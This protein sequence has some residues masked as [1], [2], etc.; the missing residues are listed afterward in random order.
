[1]LGVSGGGGSETKTMSEWFIRV[2]ANNQKIENNDHISCATGFSH[3]ENSPYPTGVYQDTRYRQA[4]NDVTREDGWLTSLDTGD[5]GW[6]VVDDNEAR[7]HL[8]LFTAERN[9]YT[10]EI[11]DSALELVQSS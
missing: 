8:Q 1:L 3:L 11:V 6:D 9:E 2:P 7:L 5:G 10:V 4:L